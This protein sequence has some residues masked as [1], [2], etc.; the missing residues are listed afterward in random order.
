MIDENSP[1]LYSYTKKKLQ[2]VLEIGLFHSNL[3]A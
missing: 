2:A 3:I 1:V